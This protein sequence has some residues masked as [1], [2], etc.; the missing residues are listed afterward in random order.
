MHAMLEQENARE[1]TTS[2]EVE[3]VASTLAASEATTTA[4]N[5]GNTR[6]CTINGYT[7]EDQARQT[8]N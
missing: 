3:A 7:P 5:I 2:R 4:I 6:S 8:R 1:A